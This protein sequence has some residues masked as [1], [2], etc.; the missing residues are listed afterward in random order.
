MATTTPDAIATRIRAVAE[1]TTCGL[2]R[3][4]LAFSHDAQPSSLLTDT[5]W[6][7]YDGI[8]LQQPLSNMAERRI[9]AWT[10]YVARLSKLDMVAATTTMHQTLTTIERELIADGPAQSYHAV[11]TSRAITNPVSELLVGSVT[12]EADYDFALS[13]E[14]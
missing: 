14:E 10:I 9:D 8:Q 2:T 7:E 11:I 13:A 4:R 5:Y 3:S 12:V 1:G 6:V